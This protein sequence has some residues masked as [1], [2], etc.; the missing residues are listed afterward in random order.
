MLAAVS[1]SFFKARATIDKI[2]LNAA[3]TAIGRE[4]GTRVEGS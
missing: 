2:V 4:S 3:C 1:K